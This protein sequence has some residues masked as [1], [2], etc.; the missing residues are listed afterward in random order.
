MKQVTYAGTT[1]ITG[2]DIAD[3]LVVLATALGRHG[4]AA[5]VRVPA[6]DE[7]DGAQSLDIVFGSSNN[8]VAVELFPTTDELLDTE[9]VRLLE[10]Q[11]MA[12][13]GPSVILASEALPSDW[14]DPDLDDWLEAR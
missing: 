14:S 8:L 11:T 10:E 13:A 3:A 1:F 7:R 12:V 6:V 9:C 5:A 2:T 4:G